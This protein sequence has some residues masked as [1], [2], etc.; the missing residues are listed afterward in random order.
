MKDGCLKSANQTDKNKIETV[1]QVKS[2]E[3]N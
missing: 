3:S 1:I 2:G